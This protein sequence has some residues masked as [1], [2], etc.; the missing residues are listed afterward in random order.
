MNGNIVALCGIDIDDNTSVQD[1]EA[2]K[3]PM[4]LIKPPLCTFY[5]LGN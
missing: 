1:R 5:G 4:V 2:L 3:Y